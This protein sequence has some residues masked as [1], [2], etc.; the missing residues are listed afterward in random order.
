MCYLKVLAPKFTGRNSRHHHHNDHGC[1]DNVDGDDDNSSGS[2]YV[3]SD[4][5]DV[6]SLSEAIDIVEKAEIAHKFSDELKVKQLKLYQQQEEERSNGSYNRSF[7]MERFL[8]DATA[9]AAAS[10]ALNC[11]A[12]SP[13]RVARRP[14]S[15]PKGCGLDVLFPWRIKYHHQ[16]CGVKSPVRDGCRSLGSKSSAKQ[17]KQH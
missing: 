6:L 9:L 15:P 5:V 17:K 11:H 8:P 7:M 13:Q 2:G 16:L 12:F 4:G 3:L 14:L 1:D 10:S